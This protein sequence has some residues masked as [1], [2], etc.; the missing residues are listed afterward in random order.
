M[1]GKMASCHDM[2]EGEVY[3]C[4]TCGLELQVIKECKDAGQPVDSC[5]CHDDH[6]GCSIQ[7]CGEALSKKG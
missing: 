7:C 1:G 4:Q 5:G 3:V 2:K 6:S